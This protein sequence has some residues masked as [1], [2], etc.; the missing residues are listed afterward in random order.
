L[1]KAGE[2][3]WGPCPSVSA[4]ILDF[5]AWR[6]SMRVALNRALQAVAGRA[7]ELEAE[8]ARITSWR[9][10]M[11]LTEKSMRVYVVTLATVLCRMV[12]SVKLLIVELARMALPTMVRS[13]MYS[14]L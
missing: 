3:S 14:A 10:W 7:S 12:I 9:T 1:A 8:K 6:A 11:K 2:G 13:C 4:V 5:A